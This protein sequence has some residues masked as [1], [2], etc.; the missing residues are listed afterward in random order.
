MALLS[1]AIRDEVYWL[2]REEKVPSAQARSAQWTPLVD[3]FPL[4]P[5]SKTSRGR[6][7]CLPVP[8]Y[9]YFFSDKENAT[10]KN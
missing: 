7:K 1:C 9:Y 6:V 2:A 5:V 3:L 10:K 4:A 8:D